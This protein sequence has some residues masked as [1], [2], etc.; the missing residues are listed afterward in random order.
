[1]RIKSSWNRRGFLG[2]AAAMAASIFAPRKLFSTA[3]PSTAGNASVSGF[4]QSGNPY[5]ELGVT[6]LADRSR[7]L[8]AA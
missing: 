3:A 1:M 7:E 8:V 2:T 6:H 5:D 4:G